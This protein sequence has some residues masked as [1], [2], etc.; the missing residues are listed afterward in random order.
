MSVY[1]QEFPTIMYDVFGNKKPI[2]TVDIFRAVRIKNALRDDV[3]MYKNYTIQDNERPDHASVKL[4]GTGDYYWTFFVINPNLT[5]LTKDWP[6]S[7]QELVNKINIKYTGNVLISHDS[8]STKF[9][10]GEQ[11]VGL[12]SRATANIISKDSNI[13][14]IQIENEVGEFS[15][16]ELIMGM[17][18]KHTCKIDSMTTFKYA[19]HHYENANGD[20]VDHEAVGAFPI[21]NEEWEYTEN[22]KKTQIRVVRP[23]YISYF[24]EQFFTL[25]NPE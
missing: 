10:Q 16:N 12:L 11:I 2:E 9:I 3:T 24:A 14:Q 1:F 22:E 25:I 4:Y 13:H 17:T 7:N 21:T 5:H 19:P 15:P 20:W 8:F 23:E 18:S 6:L